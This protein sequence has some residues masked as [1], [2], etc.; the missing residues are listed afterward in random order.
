MRCTPMAVWTSNLKEDADIKKAIA[1]DV[2]M[3]HPN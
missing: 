2:E 1:E 3:S